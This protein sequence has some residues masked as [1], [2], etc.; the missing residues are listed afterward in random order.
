MCPSLKAT[1]D[2]TLNVPSDL[3]AL[4]NMDVISDSPAAKSSPGLKT[5]KYATTPLMSTYLLAF[6]VG[7]FEYI[8]GFTTGE[9]NGRPI[10]TRVYTLPGLSTQGHHALNVAMETL[11]YFAKVF[12]LPYPLPKLDM[13]AIPDFDAGAMEN[14]G[15]V[16]FRTTAVNS[17]NNIV[18]FN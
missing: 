7:P 6:I 12:D 10:K 3:T 13:V 5:V 4:S 8:E 9:Y 14:W 17:N 15:L 11:E 18:Y 1:F 2:V 16:T